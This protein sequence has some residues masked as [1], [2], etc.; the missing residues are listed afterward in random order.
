VKDA[1][2]CGDTCASEDLDCYLLD[3]HGVVQAD[4]E[5]V[6]AGRSLALVNRD[7]MVRLE[8]ARVYQRVTVYDYQGVCRRLPKST[9][10]VSLPI[11]L[12]YAVLTA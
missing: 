6:L 3:E 5:G 12:L 8:A 10:S 1:D 11:V 7:L 2:P 4:E 9:S